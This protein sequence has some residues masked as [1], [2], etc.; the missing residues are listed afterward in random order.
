MP[1]YRTKEPFEEARKPQ[2][3]L[4]FSF[5]YKLQAFLRRHVR[6]RSSLYHEIFRGTRTSRDN[7]EHGIPF[8]GLLSKSRRR[9]GLVLRVSMKV[10]W[11]ISESE[12]R[13]AKTRP[14]K[15]TIVSLY[16]IDALISCPCID[17]SLAA[18]LGYK[19]TY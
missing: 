14:R 3:S 17:S 18:R 19:L 1:S 7:A 13:G 4:D 15:T 16:C 6:V 5:D 8:A 11:V 9:R 10:H 12:G 2:Q